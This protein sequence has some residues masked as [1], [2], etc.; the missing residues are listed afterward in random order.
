MGALFQNRTP[1]GSIEQGTQVLRPLAPALT[2][3]VGSNHAHALVKVE[4][5][6]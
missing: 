1:M 5:L 6:D 2:F 4:P 3:W